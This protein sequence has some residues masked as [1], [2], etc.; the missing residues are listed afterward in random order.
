MALMDK[1][2]DLQPENATEMDSVIAL[3]ED[4][5]IEEENAEYSGVVS[6]IE[7]QFQRSKD[8]RLTDETRWLEAYRNYRG[9]YGPDVQFMETEKSRVFIKVTKTKTL[10]AYG[11][12]V[13]VLFGNQRFPITIDPT[14][15]PEGVEETVHFDPS[16]PDEL[17]EEGP[18]EQDSPYGF[19]GDGAD[20]PAGSTERSLMLAGMEEKLQGV[21]GLKKGPGTTPSAVTFHPAMVA[22][23]K[24]QKKVMDQLQ[25]CNASK[26]LRSTSFEM[27]LFGT[28]VLKGPFA[29]NKE[30]ANWD[31]EGTYTPTIKTVPQ[32]GHVSVWNFYPDPDANN[33]EEAQY[34]VERHKMSRSQ[35]INLKKR[36]FFRGNVI[37]QCVEQGEAYVKEW[38]EDDLADY[39]QTHSIDRFEV[40]EYC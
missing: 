19:A 8:R 29:V 27:S 40:L 36:P 13:D 31:D 6:F 11:Q 15:L 14:V 9:L 26:H 39:E 2:T 17:K 22:A 20:L 5:N 38:W 33:M 12:I 30:Y 28:G 24:M 37:D 18:V 25:E 4:G 7:T 16:L 35:L 23:K 34:V 3:E 10:A 32:I 1:P 21:K